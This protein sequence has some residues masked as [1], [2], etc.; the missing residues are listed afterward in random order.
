MKITDMIYTKVFDGVI[1]ATQEVCI[2]RLIDNIII[3]FWSETWKFS[4]FREKCKF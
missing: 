4:G 2:D 3:V 1:D